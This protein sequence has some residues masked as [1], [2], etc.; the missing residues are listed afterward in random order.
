VYR[1]YRAEPQP[2]SR[3]L[4]PPEAWRQPDKWLD[5]STGLMRP[6][7]KYQTHPTD[8]KG[9]VDIPDVI[10]ELKE[11]FWS[12]YEWKIDQNDQQLKPDNHHTYFT[13]ADY[14]PVNND[15]SLIPYLFREQQSNLARIP[16]QIHNAWHD[17]FDKPQKPSQKVMFD[18]IE[19]HVVAREALLNLVR[20]A[21]HTTELY[22]TFPLRR[23]DIARHPERI[24]YREHDTIAEEYLRTKFSARFS[25]Y[26]SALDE[27]IAIPQRET[28]YPDLVEIDSRPKVVATR[29]GAFV[30]RRAT[31][32]LPHFSLKAA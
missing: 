8:S 30:T 20:A 1:E 23:G 11:M 10:A 3:R 27:F 32:Y 31:N 15:D 6:S 28:A 21:Q 4:P 17:R 7:K 26:R 14:Q 5:L 19:D 24:N 16:R 13:K 18:Y 25:Y 2:L 29:L 9:L 12:D 22:G